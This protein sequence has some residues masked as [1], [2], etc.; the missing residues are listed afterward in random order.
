MQASL[1]RFVVDMFYVDDLWDTWTIF[2]G[3]CF[4]L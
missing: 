4:D 3:P 1:F 2:P